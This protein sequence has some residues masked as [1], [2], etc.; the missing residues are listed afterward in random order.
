MMMLSRGLEVAVNSGVKNAQKLQSG[1]AQI[2][3]TEEHT[4]SVTVPGLFIVNVPVFLGG[5]PVR[6]V[7]RLRYR[8]SGSNL[9][10]FYQLY[11]L[12]EFVRERVLT[13]LAVAAEK[14]GLP[15][16]EGSPEA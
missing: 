10:W 14:T 6:L 3:F 8:V 7:A 12:R 2:T 11:R 15:V 16:Y 1:E 5:A 13:D 9:V 4:T